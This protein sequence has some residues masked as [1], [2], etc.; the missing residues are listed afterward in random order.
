[1][2]VHYQKLYTLLWVYTYTYKRNVEGTFNHT[3]QV[4][5]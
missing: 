4:A 2:G 3:L 1:M 5:I